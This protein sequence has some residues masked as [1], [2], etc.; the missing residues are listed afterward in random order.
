M[1]RDKRLDPN[2]VIMAGRVLHRFQ[3]SR[4][5]IFL[6]CLVQVQR[7][8]VQHPVSQKA[9]TRQL[10]GSQVFFYQ[11]FFYQYFFGPFR[12]AILT[13]F[14]GPGGQGKGAR[15]FA[16]WY[17][18]SDIQDWD[19]ILIIV[20]AR[21]CVP[22]AASSQRISSSGQWLFPSAQG[23]KI[24]PVGIPRLGKVMASC[25]APLPIR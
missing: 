19:A 9:C 23:I 1:D 10:R 24:K 18:P 6:S 16:T 4:N 13:G 11:S 5:L 20:S 22:R 2:G 12:S 14:P 3:D 8:E 15:I 7:K 25:P 17:S 21:I